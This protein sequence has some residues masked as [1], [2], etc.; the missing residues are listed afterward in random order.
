VKSIL[1]IPRTLEYL[2]TQ[3]VA[4]MTF[5][6]EEFPAFFTRRSGSQSPLV[7]RSIDEIAHTLR[8]SKQLSNQAGVVLAVPIPAQYEA[9]GSEIERAIQFAL[10]D[11]SRLNIIGRE[12]TPFV[13]K[14][15]YEL[16][17]GRSLAANIGLVKNNARVAAEIAALF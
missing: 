1:D 7:A 6:S 16:T 4:V 2:E 3:G 15:I 8:M 9:D 12:V 13:L 17:D 14:R 10:A 11:A 5:D